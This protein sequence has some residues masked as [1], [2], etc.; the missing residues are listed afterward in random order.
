MTV[1]SPRDERISRRI[2]AAPLTESERSIIELVK[3]RRDP[4]EMRRWINF[5][6]RKIDASER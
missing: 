5:L 2:W 3:E 6:L 1:E 4:E